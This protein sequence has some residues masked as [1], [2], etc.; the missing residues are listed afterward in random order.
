MPRPTQLQQRA[1]LRGLFGLALLCSCAAPRPRR[2]VS[3]SAL[4]GVVLGLPPPAGLTTST[5][6]GCGQQVRD[7]ALQTNKLLVESFAAAG[8][9]PSLSSRAPWTLNVTITDAG[10]GEDYRR[11]KLA[12]TQWQGGD[13]GI[14][15]IPP[16]GTEG[17]VN[18]AMGRAKVALEATLLREGQLVWRGTVSGQADSVPCG[19][20]R[21]KLREALDQAIGD[22]REQVIRQV[23]LAP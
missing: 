6:D 17:G 16:A 13:P 7:L 3:P 2:E 10:M 20:V 12:P 23:H 5:P 9:Q 15:Q 11:S 19:A 4:R 21:E 1:L 18:G 8:A 22:L 14:N